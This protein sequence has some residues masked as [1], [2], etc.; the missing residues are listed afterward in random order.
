MTD[1]KVKPSDAL[2]AEE[3]ERVMKL[4]ECLPE[5]TRQ[6]ITLRKTYGYSQDEIAKRLGITSQQVE[7]EIVKAV[8]ACAD[9]REFGDEH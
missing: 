3:T 4:V 5:L 8:Q 2:D 9:M 7:D 1:W 6:V